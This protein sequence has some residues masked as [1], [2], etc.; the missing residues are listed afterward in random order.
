MRSLGLVAGFLLDKAVPDPRRGHPVALYGRAA[1]WWERRVY[2]DS[3]ARGAL[4]AAGAVLPVVAAGS[5]VR[6]G[7]ATAATTWAVLGGSML[8]REAERIAGALEDGDLAR[9]RELLPNLCGRDP[10]RLDE[11]GVARAVVESVAENTS[12]A[13]VG[14]LVW[15]ALGGVAGLAGFRA[16]NTLDAMVGHRDERYERFG[17][18]SA[19]LDDLAGWGPARLTAVLAVLAAPV[20]GGDVRGA[21]RVWRRDGDRHPSPNAGQC[22]AAFAG[23]LGRTLGG[24]NV[25]GGREERRPA[26]GDGPRAGVGDIRR[27]ARLARAVHLG[28]LAVAAAVAR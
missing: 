22:E 5:V 12:D 24:A 1:G 4:F 7:A 19:R 13:V 8:C 2:G 28:A 26:M 27:A 6:G 16:V 14:P 11:E 3:R 18:V 21:W 9:A 17:S 15:G 25:Y 10:S 20:I 23:S